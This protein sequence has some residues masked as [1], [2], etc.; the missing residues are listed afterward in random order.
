MKSKFLMLPILALTLT[1]C[2]NPNSSNDGSS[3]T[4]PPSAD[5]TSEP[6]TS[7]VATKAEID[8]VALNAFF[9][10]DIYSK[11][12]KVYSND[13]EFYDDSSDDYPVDIYIDLFDWV[14][15]DFL[16]Y[17]AELDR[18]MT[19]DEQN[20]YIVEENIF[21]Y[22]FLDDQSF[23]TPTYS[24]N[25]FK[26]AEVVPPT[27]KTEIDYT[28]LNTYF[29]FDIYA[30]IPKIY[31]ENYVY[32]DNSTPEYPVDIFIDL[33]DW[34][35]AD[36]IAFENALANLLEVDP[37]NGYIVKPNTFIYV[38]LDTDNYTP[39]VFSI[40]IFSLPNA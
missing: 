38:Y 10:D 37:E 2:F 31:S 24:I 18:T 33:L 11:I 3:L 5:V 26:L 36:A 22:V 29:G 13:Y 14:E 39:G 12:P 17:E 23:E 35:D 27:P 34:E 16:S 1:G 15:A 30:M 20:G 6:S 40:N 7:E 28:Q 21:A 9:G 4:S 25:I 19:V 32:F 8:S